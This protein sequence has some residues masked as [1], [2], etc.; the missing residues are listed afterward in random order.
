M[1]PWMWRAPVWP[2]RFVVAAA[3]FSAGPFVFGFLRRCG[4]VD[5]SNYIFIGCEFDSLVPGA[6]T[7]DSVETCF[8]NA[9]AAKSA[10]DNPTR[11]GHYVLLQTADKV[12]VNC[13]WSSVTFPLAFLGGISNFTQRCKRDVDGVQMGHVN[14]WGGGWSWSLWISDSPGHF[15]IPAD[16]YY[17]SGSSDFGVVTCRDEFDIPRGVVQSPATLSTQGD[18]AVTYT[19]LGATQQRNVFLRDA[20][21][22]LTDLGDVVTDPILARIEVGFGQA[23]GGGGGGGM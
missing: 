17:R 3:H 22:W 13:T 14:S 19:C 4:A 11:D 10:A 18:Y 2:S 20:T 5:T 1:L 15:E 9:R 8:T 6:Q 7:V 23:W 16:G 12:T 21:F